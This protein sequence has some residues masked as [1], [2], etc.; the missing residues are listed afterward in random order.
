MYKIS[1][2]VFTCYPLHNGRNPLWSRLQIG[3]LGTYGIKVE[4]KCKNLCVCRVHMI[5]AVSL[6]RFYFSTLGFP[7]LAVRQLYD[8]FTSEWE[9]SLAAICTAS[10]CSCLCPIHWSQMLIGEWRCSWTGI[11]P[12]TSEWSTIKLPTKVRLIS[13]AWR[14][15]KLGLLFPV[16]QL[17]LDTWKVLEIL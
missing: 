16:W 3:P 15:I 14:Y 8:R 7:T 12:I 4:L 5:S 11:A 17:A 13:E 1:V 6:Y 9:Y 10:S 2:I